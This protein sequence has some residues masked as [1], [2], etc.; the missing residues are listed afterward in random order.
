MKLAATK[1]YSGPPN[2]RASASVKDDIDHPDIG[3]VVRPPSILL[4]RDRSKFDV[5]PDDDQ[6]TT[7]KLSH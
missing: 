1:Q 6:H 2:C 5:A 3:Q 4:F 7:T